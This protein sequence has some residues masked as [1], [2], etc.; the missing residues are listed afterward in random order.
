MVLLTVRLPPGATLADAL[1]RLE[2]AEE[3][4]DTAFGLVPIDPGT[5][6]YAVRVAEEASHRAANTAGGPFSDPPIA[7]HGSQ[8]PHDRHA[9]PSG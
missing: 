7:P 3:D 2:L 5:G 9:P 1:A 6:L 4:V 8:D